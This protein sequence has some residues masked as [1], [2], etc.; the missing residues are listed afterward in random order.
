MRKVRFERSDLSTTEAVKKMLQ[1]LS[2]DLGSGVSKEKA[3][4]RPSAD[5]GIGPPDQSEVL[6]RGI[7]E[8]NSRGQY[9]LNFRNSR[10][11][12]EF[13]IFNQQFE[14][15]DCFL[16]DTEKLNE[17][18]GILTQI[19]GMLQRTP[20]Y[21]THII[22]LG[23]WKM[24]ELSEFPAKIDDIFNEGF[25]PEDWM[26]KAPRCAFE[27]ALNIASKYGEIDGFKEALDSLERQG[28]HTSQTFVPLSLIG[29][30]EVQ[31]VMKV[32]K[33]E[34]IEEELADF[35]VKMLG[36]LWTLYFVLQNENLLPS[37][38]E[39]SLK[40]NQMMWNNAENIFGK[41][42]QDLLNN[43]ENTLKKL[44]ERGIIWASAIVRLPEII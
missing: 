26:I 30:D 32:L 40:L 5:F 14:Q 27:L 39:F 36:F 4:W 23:W 24:L 12:Q 29:Q 19:T 20:E 17:A 41:K 7:V 44:N 43:L 21:W 16:E 38:A 22:A 2:N 8:R 37:S 42:Q 3:G 6:R 1:A 11:R 10:I 35:N 9:R 15:L 25:S 33:W 28:V 13:K 18:Q 31:K 34:E